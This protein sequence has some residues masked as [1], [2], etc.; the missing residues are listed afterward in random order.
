MKI[1]IVSDSHGRDNN[2]IFVLNK[3]K[4]IDMLIHL[5]DSNGNIDYIN[6]LVDCPVH[7]VRGNNDY[8]YNIENEKLISILDY[9][10]FLTHGHRYGV[11]NDLKRIKGVG[12]QYGANIVMYGHTHKPYIDLTDDIWMI[13]PGSISRPRQA[14]NKP[15]YIIMEMDKF[16]NT[17]FTLKYIS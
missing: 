16:G 9:K 8:Y 4:P 1:L 5:G 11:S 15:S 17:H 7:I 3:V 13:N 14:G 6:S 12:K 10:V 2:L